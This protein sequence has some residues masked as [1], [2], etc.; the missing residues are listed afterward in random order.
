MKTCRE[1][2]LVRQTKVVPANPRHAVPNQLAQVFSA[3]RR[4]QTQ[5]QAGGPTGKH[6]GARGW[7]V[8]VVYHNKALDTQCV[9]AQ[10]KPA[11]VCMP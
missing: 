3:V 10:L 1:A 11:L 8:I 2:H 7:S 6:V 4:L 5:L 9:L